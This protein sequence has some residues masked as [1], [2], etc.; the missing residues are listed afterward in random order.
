MQSRF[1]VNGIAR[2]AAIGHRQNHRVGPARHDDSSAASASTPSVAPR[3]N[4][5]P[6]SGNNRVDALQGHMLHE[7]FRLA[8]V[9]KLGDAAF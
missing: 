6:R 5:T 8:I 9:S 1:F 7:W 2:S 4:I 3:V